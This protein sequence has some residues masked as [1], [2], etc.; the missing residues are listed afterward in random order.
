MTTTKQRISLAF[1][2][3]W[4][5][6]VVYSLFAVLL[7]LALRLFVFPSEGFLRVQPT[8]VYGLFALLLVA[9]EVGCR[10]NLLRGVF[11]GQ[12]Q[13]SPAQWRTFTLHL[14]LL[15]IGLAI[16]NALMA[17]FTPFEVQLYYKAYGASLL[18][19]GGVLAVGWRQPA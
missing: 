7:G 16:V 12:L 6:L 17:L 15:F 5:T 13:R 19:I 1:S 11:G 4:R 3:L 10:V 18:F 14:S 8:V 9:L 2:L